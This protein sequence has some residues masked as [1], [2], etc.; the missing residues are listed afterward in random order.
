MFSNL[1]RRAFVALAIMQSA[2]AFAPIPLRN[3]QSSTALNARFEVIVCTDSEGAGGTGDGEKAT[4]SLKLHE[5]SKSSGTVALSGSP[6]QGSVDKDSSLEFEGIDD[7]TS[8]TISKNGGNKWQ[9]KSLFLTNILTGKT[10]AYT[11][12]GAKLQDK[13]E[14]TFD[15]KLQTSPVTYTE[16]PG[17]YG[18]VQVK[19]HVGGKGT[20]DKFEI[21]MIDA[22]GRSSLAMRPGV[23]VGIQNPLNDWQPDTKQMTYLITDVGQEHKI[24]DV[25]KM[26][27]WIHGDNNPSIFIEKIEVC[28]IKRSVVAGLISH[29]GYVKTFEINRKLC[30][31]DKK[32]EYCESGAVTKWE[33]DLDLGENPEEPQ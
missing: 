17:T 13:Q 9:F 15:V 4:V 20:N 19:V 31:N 7:P 22:N 29:H 2:A 16:D 27:A 33:R 25:E 12:A 3:F 8:F 32:W 24:G 6:W 30:E 21:K 11:G 1:G 18:D 5:G 28:G 23:G 26:F 10:Y 14:A